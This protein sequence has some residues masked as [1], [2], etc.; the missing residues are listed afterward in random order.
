M[1][2]ASESEAPPLLAH[3]AEHLSLVVVDAYNSELKKGEGFL[4]DR[5]SKRAFQAILDDWRDRVKQV[6][7][8]PLGDT[9]SEELLLPAPAL[10]LLLRVLTEMG[11]GNAVTL[12]AGMLVTAFD[13]DA[14]EN[15]A[16]DNLLAS[17]VVEPAPYR[18]ACR[19]SRWVLRIDEDGVYHE[20]DLR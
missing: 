19:G 13:L 10:R 8:D 17:G 7:E 12:T 2:T 14:D 18:L 6:G 15:G 3:G 1:A 5:A 11:Q 4:G 9:A 20:S 16:P